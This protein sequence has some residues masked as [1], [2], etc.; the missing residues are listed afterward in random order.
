MEN[1]PRAVKIER[2]LRALDIPEESRDEV[3]RTSKGLLAFLS[4]ITFNIEDSIEYAMDHNLSG[5]KA[6]EYIQGQA[7]KHAE[8]LMQISYTSSSSELE[9]F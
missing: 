8:Y 5:N 1:I 3:H 2:N 6:M 7:Q 4:G 9:I